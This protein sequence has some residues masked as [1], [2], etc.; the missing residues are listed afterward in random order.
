MF[1]L[2]TVMIDGIIRLG[3]Y[4]TIWFF[5]CAQFRFMFL[6]G[7]AWWRWCNILVQSC[8]VKN[9]RQDNTNIFLTPANHKIIIQ[10]SHAQAWQCQRVK[11][12]IQKETKNIFF[13]WINTHKKLHTMKKGLLVFFPCNCVNL[14]KYFEIKLFCEWSDMHQYIIFLCSIP[15][16]R[17]RLFCGGGNDCE[18]EA[19]WL[20][21]LAR[22]MVCT[23][24]DVTWDVI[25][26]RHM[27]EIFFLCYK[28]R[29]TIKI[30]LWRII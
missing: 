13:Y 15:F 30:K 25:M 17:V 8:V 7:F 22:M 14:V 16:F 20:F 18:K 9:S 12:W 21:P 26:S 11:K 1:Y 2:K 6:F 10:L 3:N 29:C 19:L 5:V 23:L 27:F 28:H 24:A 4:V